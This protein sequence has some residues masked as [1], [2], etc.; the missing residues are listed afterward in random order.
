LPY[1]AYAKLKKTKQLKDLQ[2]HVD[3]TSLLNYSKTKP[4]LLELYTDS[5]LL[6]NFNH[7]A[8]KSVAALKTRFPKHPY[9]FPG[10][11]TKSQ[12]EV[13]R[14][15]EKDEAHQ[16]SYELSRDFHNNKEKIPKVKA[17]RA[18]HKI[19]KVQEI[20]VERENKEIH[21]FFAPWCAHC[22]EHIKTL[23]EKASPEFWKKT[24]LIAVFIKDASL[25]NV[26]EFLKYSTLK[27]KHPQVYSEI[28]VIEESD[29]S[30]EFYEKMNLYAVPKFVITNKKG[31]ILNYNYEMSLNPYK[32]FEKDLDLALAPGL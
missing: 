14:N 8:L 4:H 16:Y 31:E 5:L 15:Y 2:T 3:N 9:K 22:F 10:P 13:L 6:L 30:Q 17:K 32:D 24:Q 1:L 20:P 21:I 7:L 19:P 27:E 12:E 28:F 23:S 18:F 29:E 25:K 11:L 26:E